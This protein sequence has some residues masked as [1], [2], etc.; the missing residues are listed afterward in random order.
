MKRF[1]EGV[2]RSQSTLFGMTRI[3]A[4]HRQRDI[5]GMIRHWNTP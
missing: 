4:D 1:V 3:D 5:G 2:D